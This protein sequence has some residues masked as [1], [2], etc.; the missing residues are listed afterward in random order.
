MRAAALFTLGSQPTFAALANEISVKPEGERRHCGQSVLSL[1][2]RQGLLS[3]GEFYL[4]SHFA[5]IAI[6]AG[7]EGSAKPFAIEIQITS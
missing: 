5:M 1:R 6:A 7:P 3:S 4:A 2:L